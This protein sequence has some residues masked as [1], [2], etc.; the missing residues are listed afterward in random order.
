MLFS[1]DNISDELI[2]KV[3]RQNVDDIQGNIL[4]ILKCYLYTTKS[5][6]QAL[7]YFRK[8]IETLVALREI[9]PIIL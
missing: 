9:P 2:S 1:S 4:S 7:H 3:E 5:Q 8:S 6:L